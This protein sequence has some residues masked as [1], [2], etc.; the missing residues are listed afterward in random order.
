MFNSRVELSEVP[1]ISTYVNSK[2]LIRAVL[3]NDF[4][5]FSD[6]LKSKQHQICSI[7]IPRSICIKKNA[8]HYALLN[9]NFILLNNLIN[10]KQQN[11]TD[12]P[13][14]I[15]SMELH[16][17]ELSLDQHSYENEQ[18]I[19]PLDISYTKFILKNNIS[20]DFVSK[21]QSYFKNGLEDFISNI[22]VSIK[23]GNC[24]L[25]YYLAQKM[26]RTESAYFN[27][28]HLLLLGSDFTKQLKYSE[29]N[30]Y[31]LPQQKVC[32]IHIAAINPDSYFFSL[33]I[34]NSLNS[35]YARD[36]DGWMPIHY[37]SVCSSKI[38]T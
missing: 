38:I 11:L 22:M 8:I 5:Q 21:S 13:H 17:S 25:A 7:F 3:L 30:D 4:S 37:A 28:A 14:F 32:S 18:P 23:C 34:N 6:I 9:E 35:L 1:N 20:L 36:I 24:S 19:G 15:S 12:Y 33:I 2:L 26:C 16:H 27:K 31:T 29:L 10:V